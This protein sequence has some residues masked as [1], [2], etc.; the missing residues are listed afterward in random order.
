MSDQATH[1]TV[2][3][4]ADRALAT[5][6]ASRE[7]L[8]YDA[9]GDASARA[10]YYAAID[11]MSSADLFGSLSVLLEQTHAPRPAYKP[12]ER[13]YPW[14]DL[15][16]DGRLHSIYSGKAFEA[17]EFIRADAEI[18]RRRAARFRELARSESILDCRTWF[19]CVSPIGAAP[20]NRPQFSPS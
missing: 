16:P 11:E 4:E 3:A 9:D 1:N 5:Y 18:A 15:H 10:R 19:S 6:A 7:R 2:D 17:E 14:V 20:K 8:Y 12:T 13:V